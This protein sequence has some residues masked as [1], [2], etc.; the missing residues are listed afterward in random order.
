MQ[1]P[2]NRKSA[3]R[4]LLVQWSKFQNVSVKLEGSTLFTGINGSG[5][6]TILDAVTYLITGNTQFN[7]AAKDR[8]RTVLGY[9]RGDTKSNGTARY[10]RSGEVIS[11][12]AMEFDDPVAGAPL[13][14]GVCIESLNETA[15]PASS[16]F[17]LP[18]TTLDQINFARREGNMLWITPKNE[19][20]VR[21][22]RLKGNAFLG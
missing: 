13:V 15:K 12:V 20:T 11:Y 17:I 14:V 9:V 4:L 8:D 19:L 22:E 21:G 6:S 1:T 16:W 2:M 5:K 18:E 3:T 7:K 10:L